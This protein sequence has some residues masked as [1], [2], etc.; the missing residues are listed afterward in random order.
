MFFDVMFKDEFKGFDIF[1][2]Q[3]KDF[4]SGFYKNLQDD[5]SRKVFDAFVEAKLTHNAENLCALNVKS[6]KQYFPKFLV[7]GK[8]EVFV[9]AGA[10]TGD[11]LSNF[12]D[13]TNG[14]FK[15][16]YL[17][18]GDKKNF[19]KLQKFLKQ[20]RFYGK[21]IKSLN[22]VCLDDEY[23]VINK[24]NKETSFFVKGN[25][26]NQKSCALDKYIL[27]AKPTFIKMDVEGSEC[28]A[29]Y[30]CSQTIS[31]FRPNLAV[32]VYHKKDDL[33]KIPK[34]LLSLNKNYKFYLRHY[35]YNSSELILY[36]I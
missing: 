15:S 18:E 4:I 10:Y 35:G 33:V 13:R 21:D 36:A 19:K 1:L 6:E 7:L 14:E 11:S 26:G 32:A 27:Q 2:N 23:S 9:D 22:I 24:N 8:Q 3:H 17:F 5:L 31:K 12:F 29:L 34:L 28:E 20:Q 16:T 30:G 25:E